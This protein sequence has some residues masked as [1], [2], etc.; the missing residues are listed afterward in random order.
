M[1]EETVTDERDRSVD[2]SGDERPET[3]KEASDTDETDDE[4]LDRFEREYQTEKVLNSSSGV[5]AEIIGAGWR[6]SPTETYVG[7]ICLLLSV[8]GGADYPV[9]IPQYADSETG[10]DVVALLEWLEQT[11][12]RDLSTLVGE[13]VAID[14][15]ADSE[16]E[17][18][19][20]AASDTV[21]RAQI[22][23]P[24]V[25]R[26]AD[27]SLPESVASAFKR[28]HT[29]RQRGGE[30]IR[31]AELSA[32]EAELVLGLEDAWGEIRVPV[33]RQYESEPVTPYERLVEHVGQGSVKQIEGGTIHLVHASDVP[34]YLTTAF[35]DLD[36]EQ[37]DSLYEGLVTTTTD[38]TGEWAIFLDE[39][40]RQIHPLL[41]GGVVAGILLIVLS[42]VA[43]APTAMVLAAL[44]LYGTGRQALRLGEQ[45]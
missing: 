21:V 16:T 9:I 43:R 27:P 8:P 6:D 15:T 4:L 18:V 7:A 29:Y 45:E 14:I 2:P 44:I 3:G 17:F 25:V 42:I 23:D 38:C 36:E 41:A 20:I 30:S 32:T 34:K 37:R 1:A 10:S 26:V 28:L 11:P 24:D 12:Q 13:Q 5:Q 31:I 40:S 19:R 33:E 39:P 35:T 22:V